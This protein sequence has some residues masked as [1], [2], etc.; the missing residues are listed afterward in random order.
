MAR[1]TA[2]GAINN[3]KFRRPDDSQKLYELIRVFPGW[4]KSRMMPRG[5]H[6]HLFYELL[7]L[8]SGN[9]VQLADFTEYIVTANQLLFLPQN[10]IH[11]CCDGQSAEG[12]LLLFKEDF[13]SLDQAAAFRNFLLFNPL[14]GPLL[15]TPAPADEKTLRHLFNLLLDDASEPTNFS[16]N[17]ALQSLL[18]ALLY[19][20]EQIA[21]HSA[22]TAKIHSVAN[23]DVYFRFSV[24]LETHFRT[25]HTVGFYASALHLSPKQL[26]RNLAISSRGSTT[27]Q[28]IH[29]RLIIEAKRLLAYSTHS[30][31][32]IAFTIGIEDAAYFSRLFK[33]KTGISPD[34]FRAMW[35]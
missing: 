27:Q 33:Q 26:S 6:R 17:L 4:E 5:Y 12:V 14:V 13:F 25:H 23:L 22:G 21:Q 3:A 24:L 32:E 20:V 30:V 19:K 31:K 18:Y 7:W 10:V 2:E 1:H 28:L 29:A 35:G 9:S 16:Q 11:Q 34:A 8:K 15:L